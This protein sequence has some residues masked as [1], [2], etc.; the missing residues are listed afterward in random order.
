MFPFI[1]G[2]PTERGG[3]D[4]GTEGISTGSAMCFGNLILPLADCSND[5]A[6]AHSVSQV[7]AALRSF[8][9]DGGF[10]W[11]VVLTGWTLIRPP[12]SLSRQK[13]TAPQSGPWWKHIPTPLS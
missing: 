13:D 3:Q 12:S 7:I 5:E 2:G 10:F 1:Q 8:Q 6:L 4:C 11:R 9:P